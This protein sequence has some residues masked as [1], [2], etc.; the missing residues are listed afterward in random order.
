MRAGTTTSLSCR[1]SVGPLRG[2]VGSKTKEVR[3][4]SVTTRTSNSGS[5]SDGVEEPVGLHTE[6]LSPVLARYPSLSRRA[7]ETGAARV[8]AR[9]NGP[10]MTTN[11]GAGSVS[12]RSQP[13]EQ[14]ELEFQLITHSM[15]GRGLASVSQPGG[16]RVCIGVSRY[17]GSCQ[18][19]RLRVSPN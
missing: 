9:Q 15:L 7:T 6:R 16:S 14:N 4:N 18:T 19:L 10:R 13:P 2:D 11:K 12:R 5:K 1:A 8:E 17:C 3:V